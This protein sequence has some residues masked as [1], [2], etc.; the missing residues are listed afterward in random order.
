MEKE[1]CGKIEKKY[2]VRE[3]RGDQYFAGMNE[4]N[5]PILKKLCTDTRVYPSEK[6][7]KMAIR[8]IGEIECCEFEAKYIEFA[9]VPE[10]KPM[11]RE[12]TDPK[13]WEFVA[14]VGKIKLCRR[15]VEGGREIFGYIG[16]DGKLMSAG[17]GSE[18]GILALKHF[19]EEIYQYLSRRMER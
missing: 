6:S 16:R 14:E 3:A 10:L 18:S 4:K 13:G 17:M 7:A 5:F 9:E 12:V 1:N 11:L 19:C 15:I 2:V 8:R